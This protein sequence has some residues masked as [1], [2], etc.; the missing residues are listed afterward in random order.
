MG[1][2]KTIV[3]S[4]LAAFAFALSS[5][6]ADLI[7][8]ESGISP[9]Y[10]TIQDAVTAASPGDR[11]FVKNKSGSVPYTESVTIDKPIEILPYANNGQFIVFGNY[12]ISP[13]ATNF[14]AVNNSVRIIGML[15]TSGSINASANNST[16]NA[17]EVSVLSSQMNSG[18]INVTGTGYVSRVSGNWLQSGSITTREAT[19]SGNLVNGD[20]SVNDATSVLASDT[21]YVIGNRVTTNTGALTNDGITWAND[22]HYCHIANNHVRSDT[23]NGLIRITALRTGSEDNVVLNNSC[24]TGS[25]LDN[26]GIAIIPNV[27]AGC[28]LKIENNALHDGFTGNDTG[29]TEHAIDFSGGVTAGAVVEVNY[30]VHEGWEIAFTNVSTSLASQTGNVLAPATFDVN[31]VSGQ[32]TVAEAINAGNPG[33]E[34]TDHDLSRNDVGVA[35]GSFNYNNFWPILTGGARVFIVKTPRLAIPSSTIDAEGEGFDR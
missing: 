1:S 19:I 29:A 30:N 9:L 32:C 28:R 11:V 3:P 23:G 34:Y 27:P 25:S 8:E 24:E 21:I 35:G 18:S 14:S 10:G 26:S 15:N 4:F 5:F 16:G 13:N 22:D 20:I 31:D 7:V 6:G 12:T 33:G 2:M 17:I